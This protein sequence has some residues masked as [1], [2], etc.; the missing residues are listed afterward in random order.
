MSLWI[1]QSEKYRV[2]VLENVINRQGKKNRR[3]TVSTFM[4]KRDNPEL[5]KILL[6]F[7]W[8]NFL[9]NIDVF[10]EDIQKI[11]D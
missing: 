6:C 3:R 8:R 7:K 11:T 2:N 9:S 10:I 1:N 4:E 5:K